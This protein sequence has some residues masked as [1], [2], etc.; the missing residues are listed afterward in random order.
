VAAQ[1][2]GQ[3]PLHQRRHAQAAGAGATVRRHHLR[4]VP[5]A[6]L[7]HRHRPAHQPALRLWRQGRRAAARRRDRQRHD[8]GHP[9]AHQLRRRP[10]S[11]WRRR[12]Q[13]ARKRCH[14]PRRQDDL[15]DQ[16]W[17]QRSSARPGARCAGSA[18][19]HALDDAG[20]EYHPGHRPR[21]GG[22]SRRYA[23]HPGADRRRP[24]LL[25]LQ[26]IQEDG[27]AGLRPTDFPTP[28]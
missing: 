20:T 14:R 9:P 8:P 17:F 18:D 28:P 6:A 23:S 5:D 27:G 26:P 2:Q 21:Q 4:A 3:Q 15:C 12:S 22:R 7:H 24:Q 25:R 10:V 19:A 1:E 16:R 11:R 13:R